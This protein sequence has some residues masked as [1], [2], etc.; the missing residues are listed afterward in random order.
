[1]LTTPTP[2][3]APVWTDTTPAI[4][5]L[6]A[7][8]DGL[9]AS[10]VAVAAGSDTVSVALAVGETNFSASIGVTVQEAPQVLTS[11]SILATVA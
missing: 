1:M 2:D 8:P 4:G 10:E 5:T 3:S 11:I 7:A 6:T 9:T